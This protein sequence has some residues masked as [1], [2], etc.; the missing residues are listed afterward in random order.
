LIAPIFFHHLLDATAVR[1]AII[2]G[3]VTSLLERGGLLTS[4]DLFPDA[5]NQ[6]HAL[7]GKPA[8]S[9]LRLTQMEMLSSVPELL[10]VA[11]FTN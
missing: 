4:I 5:R 10:P 3:N 2:C 1:R 11:V 7:E 6:V 8:P 9:G